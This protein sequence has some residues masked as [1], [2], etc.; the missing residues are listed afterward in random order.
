[1]RVCLTVQGEQPISSAASEV[2]RGAPSSEPE[3]QR[4]GPCSRTNGHGWGGKW[5]GKRFPPLNGEK[6]RKLGRLRDSGTPAFGVEASLFLN[7]ELGSLMSMAASV[8][9]VAGT[10]E[11]AG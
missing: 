9:V 11:Q 1:M 7:K 2:F 10:S 3:G 8:V 4:I 6:A 5:G